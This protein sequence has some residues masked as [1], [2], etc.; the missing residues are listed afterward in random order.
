MADANQLEL[1]LVNLV[2]NARDAMPGGGTISIAA[3]EESMSVGN[4][5]GL[6]PG[7]YVC[8]CVADTGEGMDEATL[9][10]ATEPFFTTK[11]IG[12]GTGLGLSMVHGL[13][14]QSGGRLVLKSRKGEGTTAEIWLPVAVARRAAEEAA[15]EPP[16]ASA[17]PAS[18]RLRVLAVEDD[19]QV[20]MNTV[21]MLEDLG[22]EVLEAASGLQALDLLRGTTP[23]DVV[24]TDLAMPG[25][26][27]LHLADAVRAEWPQ[28]KVVVTTGYADLAPGA[29]P[30][31]PRL[32]KPFSL[33]ALADAL[34]RA[35]ANAGDAGKVVRFRARQT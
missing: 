24:V 17:G 29:D 19:P 20:L 11:G 25:M 12:K 27:G 10:R 6:A 3:H 32:D 22:H 31:V 35:T 16:K 30:D 18:R 28:V 9:A 7:R 14:E 23:V 21:A 13:A 2:V 34:D 1:A 4:G 26:T 15:A 5:P 33:Q 8:L